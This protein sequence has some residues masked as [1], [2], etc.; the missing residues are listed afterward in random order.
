M[1]VSIATPQ[2]WD[3]QNN[4]GDTLSIARD[5]LEQSPD[6]WGADLAMLK[7]G[8][9]PPCWLRLADVSSVHP[10]QHVITLGFPGLAF[11]S[12]TL[13]SGIVSARLKSD[14]PVGV[15]AQGAPVKPQNDFIRVQMPLSPGLSGAAVI[16]DDN[17]VIS[18]VSSAGASTGILDALIQTANI[19]EKLLRPGQQPNVD[20]PWAVGQLAR[21]LRDYASPGYG[22]SVPVSYLKK[23]QMPIA[24]G[25]EPASPSRP[26]R[27]GHPK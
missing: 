9:T 3:I 10:G 27:Q 17:R 25:R 24:T 7:S 13:Y 14:L 1:V 6:A 26:L 8:H 12:L 20:W 16:D 19:Q 18:V 23:M 4:N 11:G 2:I 15:S 21:N 5:K 22:D